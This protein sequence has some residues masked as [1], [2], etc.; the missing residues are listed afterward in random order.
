M[1]QRSDVYDR[2]NDLVG[3]LDY[4]MFIV[5]SR[6]A[7]GDQAGCLIGFATQ[8]SIDPPRVLVCISKANRTYRVTQNADVLAVHFVPAEATELA[9]LFGGCTGDEHDKFAECTWQEGPG[10]VPIL[11]EC[12]NWFVGRVL[13][14]IDLGDHAGFL[15]DPFDVSYEIPQSEF[16]FHRARRIEPGHEA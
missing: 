12:R 13:E 15:L 9:N 2:F 10:G 14:R 11:A 5:T 6:S 7:E 16:S 8:C 4:P 3:D 1:S